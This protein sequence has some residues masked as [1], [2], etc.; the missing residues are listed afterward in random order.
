MTYHNSGGFDALTGLQS[1]LAD[2]EVRLLLLLGENGTGKTFTA[3][4]FAERILQEYDEKKRGYLPLFI[5]CE[6]LP[7][8]G[9][10]IQRLDHY[11]RENVQ[12]DLSIL[13]IR[14]AINDG[15]VVL[16]LDGFE[17]LLITHP[18]EAVHLWKQI[19]QFLEGE[20]AKVL[21]T[22][23][24]EFF[25]NQA[26]ERRWVGMLNVPSFIWYM[27]PF[28]PGQIQEFLE[29]S[30]RAAKKLRDSLPALPQGTILVTL[31]E[32]PRNIQGEMTSERVIE[33]VEQAISRTHHT[34]GI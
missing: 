10:L 30:S 9:T 8:D 18:R 26:E 33:L 27:Q 21:V 25:E 24:T 3:R 13:H 22:C 4:M 1:W 6:K 5:D 31:S 7:K 12:H 20:R 16:V 19:A 14:E 28:T 29:R 32:P 15:V 34:P 23:R 17:T 2:E 11:C